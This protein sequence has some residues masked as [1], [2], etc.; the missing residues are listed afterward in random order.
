MWASLFDV[1]PAGAAGS[2]PAS[3]PRRDVEMVAA[4]EQKKIDATTVDRR[5]VHKAL[6]EGGEHDR[7]QPADFDLDDSTVTPHRGPCTDVSDWA[8]RCFP[9][10]PGRLG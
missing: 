6:V 3:E 10:R 8:R 1:C 2:A 4:R 7:S 9:Q 5:E